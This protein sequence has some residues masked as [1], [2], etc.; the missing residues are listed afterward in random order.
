MARADK[1]VSDAGLITMLHPAARAGAGLARNHGIGEIP[2]C[3]RG[4]NAYRLLDTH[5]PL[6]ARGRW[7]HITVNYA[8]LARRNHSMKAAP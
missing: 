4:D 6:V 7:D 1:G 8:W 2:R 5:D 3:D